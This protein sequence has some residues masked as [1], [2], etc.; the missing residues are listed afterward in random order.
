M[1]RR[2]P[3]PYTVA[4]P[5]VTFPDEPLSSELPVDLPAGCRWGLALSHDIDHLS[6]G[7]HVADGQL[8]RIVGNALRKHLGRGFAPL[9]AIRSVGQGLAVL[10]GRDAWAGAVEDVL[11]AER[12][13][14]VKSSWFAAVRP[15]LGI[16][17][18]PAA[19]A[20]VVR[21]ILA[22]GHEIGLH[23]QHADDGPRLAAEILE[24]AQL[25]GRAVT[26]L[27]MHYLR[28]TPAVYDAAL[29]SGLSYDSTVM[30]RSQLDPERLPLAGPR[31]VRPGLVEI[32]LHVMDSTLFSATGLAFDEGQAVDY[33]RRLVARARE[34]GR[35]LVVNL[36][37]NFYSRFTPEVRGWYD[38]LL[39]LATD[40]SDVF[41]CTLEGLRPRIAVP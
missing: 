33:F 9:R 4:R 3:D 8:V 19:L 28:L 12:R 16:R 25:A 11:A 35:V 36:H 39:A 29:R 41:L 22:E 26:G 38:A 20:P 27:R 18:T 5:S 14:G 32:P 40:R 1:S 6:L 23:G 24:L 17:Y 21:R 31:L 34:E 7:E 10:A 37:P 30:D 2:R 15:G 13:A